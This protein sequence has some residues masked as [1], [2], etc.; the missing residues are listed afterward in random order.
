MGPDYFQW[1][2]AHFKHGVLWFYLEWHFNTFG[3]KIVTF[4]KSHN[5]QLLSTK[6]KA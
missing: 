3:I 5:V 1:V 4:H 2:Y 6:S